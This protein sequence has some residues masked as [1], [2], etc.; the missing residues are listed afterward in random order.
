M[1][2]RRRPDLE[3]Y[4]VTRAQNEFMRDRV[5]FLTTMADRPLIDLLANAYFIG[6][7][8]AVEHLEAQSA[9]TA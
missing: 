4:E 5:D 3:R 2:P 6:M 7:A 9:Q 8:E 1:A